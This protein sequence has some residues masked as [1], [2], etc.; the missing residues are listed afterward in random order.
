MKLIIEPTDGYEVVGSGSV[1]TFYQKPIKIK[2]EESDPKENDMY[3]LFKFLD[4]I[5]TTE[6]DV[7]TTVDDSTIIISLV[8]YNNVLGT[9]TKDPFRIG[10]SG[11]NYLY[12]HFRVY[13][14]TEKSDKLL[15]Y[16]IFT[17]KKSIEDGESVKL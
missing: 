2:I 8:N 16:T 11:D 17:Q 5:S 3:I 10:T 6:P 15:H 9:G 7:K 1:F 4:D 13:G 14:A 12:L